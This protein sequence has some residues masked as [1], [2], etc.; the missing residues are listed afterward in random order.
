MRFNPRRSTRIHHEVD[1]IHSR[2]SIFS[3]STWLVLVLLFAGSIPW[4]LPAG[5]APRI[6][7]GLPFWVVLSVGFTVAI[8]LFAVISMHRH[9]REG[10]PG[11]EN[12]EGP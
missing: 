9:W 6:W 7:L 8:A 4:Y 10:G 11:P 12:G 3:G 1:S 5:G 2:K